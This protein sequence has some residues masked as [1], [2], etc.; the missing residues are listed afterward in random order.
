MFIK[1]LM[2]SLG[3]YLLMFS[4]TSNA[5]NELKDVT[6]RIYVS[7]S[8]PPFSSLHTD[9][10]TPIGLDI[11]IIKELQNRLGFKLEEDRIYALLRAAQLKRLQNNE[12]DILGGSMSVTKKRAQYMH[13]SPIYFD[14]GLG[15][16]YSSKF[17]N[18]IKSFNDLKGKRIAVVEGTSGET[19]IKNSGIAKV[20]IPVQNFTKAAL[21]VAY[22][23]VDAFVYDKPII[24]TFAEQMKDL[25]LKVTDD[26]FA[27]ESAQYAFAYPKDSP[28]AHIFDKEIMNMIYDGTMSD[29]IAKYFK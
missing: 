10:K 19:F 29:L 1:T 16:L 13:F 24:Q 3:V 15:I 2:A 28:Y 4:S 8:N 17:N 7:P 25:N 20:V 21:S 23:K 27:R 14:S 11:D 26:L 18:K 22:N 6:L 5:F 9:Y 12:C